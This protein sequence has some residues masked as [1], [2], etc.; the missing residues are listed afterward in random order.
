MMKYLVAASALA[1]VPGSAS[2]ASLLTNGGFELPSVGDPCCNTVPPDPLPGWTVDSG[3]VNVVNGTFNGV[4][5]GTNLAYEGLQYLDLVGQGGVGSIS[6]T[7]STI[8][9]QTYQVSFAY[10]RNLFSGIDPITGSFSVDGLSE[11]LSHTGGSNSDLNWVTYAGSFVATGSSATLSFQSGA[12]GVNEGLFLDA[13]SVSGAIPEP[14]TWAMLILGFG[15][16]G[17]AMR[18]RSRKALALA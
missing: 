15:V 8:A 18:V 4:P 17:G 1:L 5:A 12:G 3:N 2:A 16:I 11:S 6:Q 13:V 9:G 10:S 14:A 7:F